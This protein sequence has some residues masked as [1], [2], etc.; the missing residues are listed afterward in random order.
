[1]DG[2]GCSAPGEHDYVIWPSVYALLDDVT[3]KIVIKR[4]SKGG[5]FSDNNPGGRTPL[6]AFNEDLLLRRCGF[7]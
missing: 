7:V 1:M 5:N 4:M 2:S 3:T 6:F